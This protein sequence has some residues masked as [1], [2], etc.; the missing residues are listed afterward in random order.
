M[1][2]SRTQDTHGTAARIH[3]CQNQAKHALPHG[4]RRPSKHTLTLLR[5]YACAGLVPAAGRPVPGPLRELRMGFQLGLLDAWAGHPGPVVHVRGRRQHLAVRLPRPLLRGVIPG[6]PTRARD[7]ALRLRRLRLPVRVA[8]CLAA[9]LGTT[10]GSCAA[11]KLGVEAL[12]RLEARWRHAHVRSC[13][14]A[15]PLLRRP[16][17]CVPL[18]AA[19]AR[20]CWATARRSWCCWAAGRSWATGC[21]AGKRSGWRWR[22][23]AW[24]HTAWRPASAAP[25]PAGAAPPLPP[26]RAPAARPWARVSTSRLLCRSRWR[27]APARAGDPRD[28]F[29]GH[30]WTL[31]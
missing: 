16:R 30:A 19:A 13:P 28:P 26:R 17:T 14:V 22:W 11:H 10:L 27:A 29:S 20:R 1:Y 2:P 7:A 15:K 3:A 23:R 18:T 6:A 24:S 9:L 5:A 12:H 8:A 31:G 21:P 4:P 25:L